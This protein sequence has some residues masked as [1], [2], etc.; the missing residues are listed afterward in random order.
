MLRQWKPGGN[1]CLPKLRGTGPAG[2]KAAAVRWE[3]TA[4]CIIKAIN[5]SVCLPPQAEPIT[6]CL[7]NNDSSTNSI[8]SLKKALDKNAALL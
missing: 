6:S 5:P 1:S 8:E 4:Y 3:Q 7:L 2:A